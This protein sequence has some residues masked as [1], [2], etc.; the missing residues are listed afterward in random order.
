MIRQARFK[1]PKALRAASVAEEQQSKQAGRP[2]SL[3]GEDA[4]PNGSSLC[5]E[6]SSGKA[7]IRRNESQKS[8]D[9]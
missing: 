6:M 5:G 4:Y 8:N 2:N 9:W 1:A 3:S 7:A